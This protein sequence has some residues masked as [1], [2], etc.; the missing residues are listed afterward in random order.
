VYSAKCAFNCGQESEVKERIVWP[1]GKEIL[2]PFVLKS[3]LLFCFQ[4][5]RR[6]QNPFQGV[7]DS[8]S[9][10]EAEARRMWSDADQKILYVQ[11]L[12]R[13]L[14][15]YAGHRDVR[16]DPDH[17]RFYFEA[18]E[19][20]KPRTIQYRSLGGRSVSRNVVWQP[21]RK[22]TGERRN[23]WWHV[24]AGLRFHQ[25]GPFQ[26]IFSVRPEWHLTSD[27]E[28]P[29]PSNRIG[30][31]VTSKKSRMYNYQYLGEVNFWRDFLS[32]GSP[33]ITLAFGDQ[34][35]IVSAEIITVN[36][37]WPGILGDIKHVD[38]EQ[39]IDDLFSLAEFHEA[40]EGEDLEWDEEEAEF[41]DENDDGNDL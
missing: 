19:I 28:T 32:Q 1:Q 33:R 13:S 3:G 30:R 31:R 22:K 15:K 29:L 24:A 5:L 11:M 41:Q 14:Y 25:V 10:T 8:S 18:M 4:N 26:W 9:V 27:G 12:N 36:V 2:L 20:G 37:T 6:R 17:R 38:T 39:R 34:T 7:I 16:Y 40:I 21:V 35:A 23:Y